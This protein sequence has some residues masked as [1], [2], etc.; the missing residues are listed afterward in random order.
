MTNVENIYKGREK[1]IWGFK[2]RVFSFNYDEEFEE[3]LK[4]KTSIRNENVL[5]DHEKLDRLIDLV[6]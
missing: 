5:I 2:N 3:R 6:T 1:I 4:S